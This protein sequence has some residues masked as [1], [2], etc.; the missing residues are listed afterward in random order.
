LEQ[1]FLFHLLNLLSEAYLKYVLVFHH[2]EFSYEI[3]S[4]IVSL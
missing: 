1:L 3:Y 4:K 2:H